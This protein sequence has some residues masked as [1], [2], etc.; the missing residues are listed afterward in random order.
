[1]SL[2]R[3]IFEKFEC[4]AL[5]KHTDMSKAAIAYK[6]GVSKTFVAKWCDKEVFFDKARTGAPRTALT[7]KNLDK[8]QK[9]EVKNF[10][11]VKSL[12][13][14][15]IGKS[16]R[17]MAKALGISPTSVTRGFK[18]LG[19]YAYRLST[20][21]KLTKKHVKVRYEKAKLFRKYSIKFYERFLISDEKIWTV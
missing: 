5:S 21:S 1:M 19:L 15:Q 17:V 6:L 9:C 16:K 8:L 7:E 14:G 13:L 11:F 10:S 3:S 20:Q 4:A 2:V 18:E 12:F